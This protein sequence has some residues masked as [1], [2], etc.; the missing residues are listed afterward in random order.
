MADMPTMDAASQTQGV[1]LKVSTNHALPENLIGKVR[2]IKSFKADAHT[3]PKGCVLADE[4]QNEFWVMKMIDDST[5]IKVAVK[6]GIES[7]DKIEII[8]PAFPADDRILVTGN[9]GLSDT[10]KVQIT[11]E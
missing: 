7:A 3:L 8:S 6:N 10:A 11:K 2:V 4:T 5:A 9:Y 1:L